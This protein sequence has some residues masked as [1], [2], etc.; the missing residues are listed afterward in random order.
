MSEISDV[1]SNWATTCFPG[2]RDFVSQ[3]LPS[4][5]SGVSDENG[6]FFPELSAMFF[7]L[8]SSGVIRD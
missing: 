2:A 4:L 3:K 1:S 7:A 5:V 8:S 6:F